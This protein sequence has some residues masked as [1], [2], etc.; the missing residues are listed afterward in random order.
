[1]ATVTFDISVSVDGFVTRPMPGI[2]YPIG[3]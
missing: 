3:T 1:M 2:E